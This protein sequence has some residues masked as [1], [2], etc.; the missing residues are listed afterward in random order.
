MWT[1]DSLTYV[2][3]VLPA[4]IQAAMVAMIWHR[5][6]V[7]LMPWFFAFLCEELMAAFATAIA[8]IMHSGEAYFYV[9]WVFRT[10]GFAFGLGAIY[11]IFLAVFASFD[12]L[13]RLSVILFRWISV[14]L[15][16][17]AVVS[18]AAAPG[19]ESS[20]LFTGLIVLERSVRLVQVG[21][22]L[23]MFLLSSFFGVA[24]KNHVFGVAL[25]LA[26]VTSLQ[27][28]VIAMRARFGTESHLWFELLTGL[29]ET[30]GYG[31]A[32]AFV[33]RPVRD[34]CWGR[35]P[36]SNLEDWNQALLGLLDR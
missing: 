9:F 22:L 13:R 21:L 28:A 31:V 1:I 14:V 10:L 20:R 32:L 15:V 26:V 25:G 17:A 8:Y 19:N 18:A 29:G 3:W 27:L 34:R 4:A 5:R 2:V 36:E 12:G 6:Q 7:H 16:L 35:L 11:D 30:G 33:A 23:S 24:W